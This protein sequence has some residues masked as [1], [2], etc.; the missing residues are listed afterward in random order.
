MAAVA[1]LLHDGFYGCGTG[2][3]VSNRRFLEVL[4]PLLAPRCRLVVMPVRVA[5]DS[6]EY[7]RPWHESMRALIA[8]VDGSV[9]PLDNGSDGRYR[10]GSIANWRHLAASAEHHLRAMGPD[11]QTMVVI[12]DVP[13]L[14]L[15]GR[16][17]RTEARVVFVP[18][19]SLALHQRGHPE[20]EWERDCYRRMEAWGTR[21]GLISAFMGR[22]LASACGVPPAS[23]IP[24]FDGVTHSEW[25][26]QVPAIALPV[27]AAN[28]FILAMGRAHPYK[29]FD[30]LLDALLLLQGGGE[31]LPHLV[32]AAVTEDD[33]PSDYQQHLQQ[34]VAAEQLDV[35]VITRFSWG[36]RALIG[37]PALRAVIV[38]SRVEPFGRI[39]MEVYSNLRAAGGAVVAAAA[40]GLAEVVIDG[41]T[42]FA[43][44][45]GSGPALAQ[46]IARALRASSGECAQ[47][48]AAGRRLISER[49]HYER[50]VAEFMRAAT[51]AD[52]TRP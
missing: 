29:G 42:G 25:S 44:Q 8:S 14:E 15:P 26:E 49:Y 38:P 31:L 50:N 4:A 39:P 48:H 17:G 9:I 43:F 34:R 40:D 23:M 24:V 37:H 32:L 16:L 46:A 27:L 35:T 45:A 51:Q 7:D 12:F 41:R 36:V 19:G 52:H 1:V 18:R 22:H 6:N 21:V 3:G 13:F 11:D 33:E 28:G 5:E 2:A 30:D 20:L 47:L 10:F